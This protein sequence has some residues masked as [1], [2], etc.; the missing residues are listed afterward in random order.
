MTAC[1][2]ALEEVEW[3]RMELEKIEAA[4]KAHLLTTA[5]EMPDPDPDP[6][7][8]CMLMQGPWRRWTGCA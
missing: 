6:D 2:G 4:L 1:T 8:G 7:P 3:P 5:G